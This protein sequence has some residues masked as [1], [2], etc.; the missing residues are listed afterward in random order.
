MITTH[1]FPAQEEKILVIEEDGRESGYY[2]VVKESCLNKGLVLI[3]GVV[4][5]LHNSITFLES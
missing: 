3:V 4:C 2:L 1:P 5:E